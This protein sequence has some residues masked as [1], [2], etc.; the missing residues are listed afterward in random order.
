M[1]LLR[2]RLFSIK[3]LK[4]NE[5]LFLA[6]NDPDSFSEVLQGDIGQRRKKY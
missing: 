2:L 5:L 3:L 4:M 6:V 1:L